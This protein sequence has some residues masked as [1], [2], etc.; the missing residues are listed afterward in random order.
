[1]Y[2]KSNCVLGYSM[3]TLLDKN[4][5]NVAYVLSEKSNL[6][7]L[8]H[9]FIPVVAKLKLCSKKDLFFRHACVTCSELPSYM[10]TMDHLLPFVMKLF[11]HTHDKLFLPTALHIQIFQEVVSTFHSILTHGGLDFLDF[12]LKFNLCKNPKLLIKS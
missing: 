3:V 5:E 11:L 1:L 6:I 2:G 8:R 7:F 9:L 12:Q 10:S 4:K